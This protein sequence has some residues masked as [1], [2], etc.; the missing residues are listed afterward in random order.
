MV[1]GKMKQLMTRSGE[2]ARVAATAAVKR[3]EVCVAAT[4][5]AVAI[6]TFLPL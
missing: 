5:M 2:D 3:T 1:E 6:F 4:N